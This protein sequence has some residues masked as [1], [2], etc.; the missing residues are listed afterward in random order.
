VTSASLHSASTHS[1][2]VPTRMRFAESVAANVTSR[3]SS[4]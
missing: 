1:I 2:V 4:L 3:V